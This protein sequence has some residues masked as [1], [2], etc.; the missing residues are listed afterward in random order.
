MLKNS[1]ERIKYTQQ[2][3]QDLE[4]LDYM[5][6]NNLIE[7]API[8]IGAE[9]EFCLIN[10]NYLPKSNS[11]EVLKAI[12]DD[13]FTTEIGKY[14]LELNSD[15]LELKDDCFSAL[16][17][18]ILELLKKA[19]Q[20]A[21]AH[22]TKILITGIL[23][24]LGIE[25]VSED[26]MTEVKRYGVINEAIKNYKGEDFQIHIKGV[27][28]LNL[29][30]KSVMLEASCTSFQTHL[31][32]NPDE[33][34]KK[35]NWSQAI[36]GP[37]LSICAN[38][39]IVFGKELWA[40]SRIALFTQSVDTRVSKPVLSDKLSRVS[41]GDEWATGSISNIYKKSFSA[42]RSLITADLEGDSLALVKNG[43]IPKLKALNL[44]NGTVYSWNRLCYGVGGGKPH[45]RIEC[46]YIP[47]GPTITDEI[48]NMVFWTGVM[49]GQPKTY[50]NLESI[51][52]FKDVKC[53][54]FKAARYGMATQFYWN[55]A[56]ISAKDLLL[57]EFLPMAYKGLYSV[58]VSPKD[59]E[60]YLGVIKQRILGHTGSQWMVK[61][62][63]AL[64]NR[65][66]PFHALQT[67][68]KYMYDKQMHDY[69]VS[70][71]NRIPSSAYHNKTNDLKV[72][73]VMTTKL[74]TVDDEESVALT[75]QIMKWNN[76]HH[77]PVINAKKELCGLV[78]WTDVKDYERNSN[79]LNSS[80]SEI[81]KTKVLTISKNDALEKAKTILTDNDINCL[82]V[83]KNKQ[84]L[85]ILTSNDLTHA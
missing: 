51:M 76:V 3:I 37:I 70:S 35:Y 23:P 46:R 84:L 61:N 33:L 8:R 41:F 22:D 19:Q 14:N 2:L 74:I 81:M 31:Q 42:Y 1:K 10:D 78:T 56:Y 28:E 12:D 38:S 20:T 5:V 43:T 49:L 77:M 15:P 16:Y 47:S 79:I 18:Q 36:A 4:A 25:H 7:K 59:A 73:H 44:H 24:T 13:H 39:P 67:M 53:N 65:Q 27:N 54:F 62:Y 17:R 48:A 68:T 66:K 30:Q 6:E 64:Q 32:I 80:I 58:G 71:W 50:D 11:L 26:Y 45:L 63:R 60:H 9:Q 40:E 83:V 82:P 75:I 72:K 55:N 34:V 52:D 57:N 69:P 85:G 29:K 21:E